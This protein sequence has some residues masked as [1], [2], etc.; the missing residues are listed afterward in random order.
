MEVSSV[1]YIF[2][3]CR[4]AMDGPY[5]ESL[6]GTR[7][8]VLSAGALPP[9]VYD[10]LAPWSHAFSIRCRETAPWKTCVLG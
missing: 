4:I 8:M 1:E 3:I 6:V 7:N 10:R 5:T 9:G 2:G